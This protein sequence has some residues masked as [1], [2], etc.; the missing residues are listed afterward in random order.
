MERQKKYYSAL[1]RRLLIA[2][3]C[4]SIVPIV[5]FAWIMKDAVEDTNI[6][7]LKELAA[8]TIEHR[9]DVIS[10]FLNEKISLLSMMV[11]FYPQDFFFNQ[12][13]LDKLYLAMGP[14][15]D[16]VDLQVID[17]AGTQHGYVGPYRSLVKDKT[18]G[19][20]PWFKETLI[21]GVH[22]SDVFTGYRNV[23]HFVVAVTD[24]LK[25]FVL[26][27]TINS[28]IFNSLLHSAQLGPH[29]DAFIINRAGEFQ[30]PSLL[31]RI[32]LTDSEKKLI[33]IDNKSQAVVTATD[34]Y[35]TRTIGNGQWLL[36]LK[37]N[38]ADSLGYYLTLRNRM[39]IIV[40]IIIIISSAAAV[41]ISVALTRNLER[42]DKEDAAH[43]LQFAHVEKMATIGRLAAGIAH[44]INNPLQ[45]I[46]NQAGW[47]SELLPEEDPAAVKNMA[48]YQNSVDK[49]R[50][51]VKRAGTITHRLLGFSKKITAQKDQV[52]INDLLNETLSFV[53]REAENNSITIVRNLAADLP[54]TMTDGP[55][56]QQVFLNLIN[57]ALDA[58]GAKGVI[59]I[60]TRKNADGKLVV[61]CCDNGPGIAPQ[62]LK[63]IFEPFFTTKDPDKGT[64]L[65]LYISYDIVKKLGGSISVENRKDGGAL[66]RITL[67]VVHYKQE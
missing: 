44:E 4:L 42:A 46:T 40:G 38:L 50:Y 16:I 3:F 27:T 24:S 18:Y 36:V 20:A 1:T 33:S 10:V 66:F 2:F 28:S 29:S 59:E 65:G 64:G 17:S 34:I 43:S 8:S 32:N 13:N 35:K 37:A 60:A 48:E 14:K 19:D 56:L 6:V 67:P 51:H 52:Q 5:S 25:H 58:V 49:I 30:T 39:I 21:S 61:E 57:N 55:Q 15:G 23:P 41:T 7:K 54:T 53:E 45:M 47:I 63:Q 26:R 31:G 62:H 12:E 11:S 22:V 9:S